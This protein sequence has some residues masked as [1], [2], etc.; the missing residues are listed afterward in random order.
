MLRRV[1]VIGG[2]GTGK[3]TIVRAICQIAD[4]H[5][6][7]SLRAAPTGRA[8][9]RLSEATMANFK[10]R[11]S[12]LQLNV[13]IVESNIEEIIALSDIV[14]TA[15]SIEVGEGPL[16]SGLPSKPHLHI[17]AVGA[18]FPGKV[19]LPLDLIKSS[20]I[21]PDFRA[22]ALVEG[23]CQ[24]LGE[25]DISADLEE[26]VRNPAKFKYVQN[27]RSVFDSTGWALE[28]QVVMDLFMEHA[29][30]LGLGQ[31]IK[32]ETISDDSKNPYHFMKRQVGALTVGR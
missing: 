8:A 11:C 15:T 12:M 24:Q 31:Y 4:A 30:A 19:E 7:R 1:L 29:F 20:F 14:C 18:D 9:R 5:G 17:N 6:W 32:I 13:D 28:D 10:A 21:C 3:T 22:Q 2:P 16:F 27:Q 26:V 25:S 23:E